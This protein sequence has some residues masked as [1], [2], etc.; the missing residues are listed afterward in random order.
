[1]IVRGL[2]FAVPSGAV[3]AFLRALR[4]DTRAA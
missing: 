1:M 4:A 2:A 3:A